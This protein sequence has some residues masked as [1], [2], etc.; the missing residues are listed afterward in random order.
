M[1]GLNNVSPN[2]DTQLTSSM[3]LTK[4]EYVWLEI[5]KTLSIAT[6]IKLEGNLIESTDKIFK[7]FNERFKYD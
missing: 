7:H 6:T 2:I 1:E 4:D 5:L 3:L